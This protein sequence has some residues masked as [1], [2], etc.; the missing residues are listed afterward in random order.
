MR[1]IWSMSKWG[2]NLV[3]DLM[4]WFEPDRDRMTDIIVTRGRISLNR[5]VCGHRLN[6]DSFSAIIRVG[7]NPDSRH[8]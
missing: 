2:V 4:G 8:S 7:F 3:G 6:L 1:S 5:S